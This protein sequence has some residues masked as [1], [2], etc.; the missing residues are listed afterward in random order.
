MRENEQPF[1]RMMKKKNHAKISNKIHI[2]C[3][4]HF[5]HTHTPSKIHCL[6]QR[7]NNKKKIQAKTK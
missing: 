4:S 1:G 5:I 2:Q 3:T 6:K 7:K